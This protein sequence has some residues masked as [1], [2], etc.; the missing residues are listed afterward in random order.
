VAATDKEQHD[1]QVAGVDRFYLL[2]APAGTASATPVP[3][4]VDFHGLAEG[5]QIHAGMTQ[6]SAKAQQEGFAVAFPNGTGTPVRWDANTASNPNHDLEYVDRMLDEIGAIRCI[7][8]SRV[9]ATGLSY[10]AIMS[11]FLTCTR[12]DRFAAVAPIAGITIPESDCNPTRA[13]PVLTVHGTADPILLFNGGV[14]LGGVL[15]APGAESTT[16]T[17]APPAQ[18][19]GPGYPAA[20]EAWAVRNGCRPDP[21]DTKVSDT[22][23]HRVWSCPAGADVEMYI[24]VGGGHSWPGSEFSRS[25]G[26]IVGPTTFDINATDLAWSFFQRFAPR[27]LTTD[28][29]LV[30]PQRHRPEE[31]RD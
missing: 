29:R 27:P 5:A 2:T 21:T 22:V 10:G 28:G 11:S 20:A 16:S 19:D 17:T 18:L 7:D 8:T 14:S 4:V 3:L 23:I 13:M 30:T 24:V 31:I 1:L 9:Y 6:F 26:K 15:P 12:T 25:I